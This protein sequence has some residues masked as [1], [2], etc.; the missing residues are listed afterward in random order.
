MNFSGS[1]W[2]LKAFLTHVSFSSQVIEMKADGWVTYIR[3]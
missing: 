2:L 3:I 1:E